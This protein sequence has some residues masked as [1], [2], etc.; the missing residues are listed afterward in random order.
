MSLNVYL[1]AGTMAVAAAAIS[2]KLGGGKLAYII[3]ASIM[4]VTC[5]TDDQDAL[6][7]K[8]EKARDELKQVREALTNAADK[9]LPTD[10]SNED[11][12]E[13]K[14][15]V[16]TFIKDIDKDCE[17]VDSRSK[18]VDQCKIEGN[19]VAGLSLAIA[20][21]SLAIAVAM[22]VFTMLPGG[23]AAG[24]LSNFLATMTLAQTS[25]TMLERRA[26]LITAALA[27]FVVGQGWHDIN[28]LLLDTKVSD[29]HGGGTATFKQP[30]TNWE[31][32]LNEK[33]T[34]QA[35]AQA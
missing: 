11:K 8:W 22:L 12:E 7:K 28:A 1:T 26:I 21:A 30:E 13:F 2:T 5:D 19:V 23:A 25:K 16:A 35:Q 34:T 31:K 27:I 29:P 24:R 18:T 4:A 6:V 9:T 15:N 17:I 10:W 14:K 32:K 20:T 3:P 33:A